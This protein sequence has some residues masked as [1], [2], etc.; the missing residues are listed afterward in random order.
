MAREVV[1]HAFNPSRSRQI[2][3]SLR[4]VWCTEWVSRTAR[5]TEKPCLEKPGG[6]K[7][8]QNPL[9]SSVAP[10]IPRDCLF[11]FSHILNHFT[12]WTDYWWN[13][14]TCML[15]LSLIFP[16]LMAFLFCCKMQ[17]Y[18]LQKW[19]FSF[20]IYF[21]FLPYFISLN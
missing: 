7:I 9:D 12:F 4:P 5:T 2:F 6:K 15:I 10:G 1:V 14:E 16:Y 3:L 11:L 13:R 18:Y 17:F 8:M 19:Q 20:H 21:C